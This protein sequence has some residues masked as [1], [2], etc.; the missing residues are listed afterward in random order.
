MEVDKGKAIVFEL[1]NNEY[2]LLSNIDKLVN[3]EL[4]NILLKKT[5]NNTILF[6]GYRLFEQVFS[7]KNKIVINDETLVCASFRFYRRSLNSCYGYLL[8]NYNTIS[9]KYEHRYIIY[10]GSLE[11]EDGEFKSQMITFSS[12]EDV[13]SKER[14][15]VFNIVED[16]IT[17]R[18]NDGDLGY[19]VNLH[20]PEHITK[21]QEYREQ[22]DSERWPIKIHILCW[23]HDF[24]AIHN[25]TVENH[26]VENYQQII[27][28]KNDIPYYEKIIDLI[29]D[30][31]YQRMRTFELTNIKDHSIGQSH[32]YP[33]RIGQKTFPILNTEYYNIGD[34]RFPVWTELYITNKCSNLSLNYF[35]PSFPFIANWFFI[36]ECDETFYDNKFSLLKYN[37]SKR[38]KK[39]TNKLRKLDVY[40]YIDGKTPLNKGFLKL[41]QQLHR[42]INFAET[43]LILSDVSLGVMMEYVG[44]TFRDTYKISKTTSAEATNY[45][46]TVK[47]CMEKFIF[48][49]IYAFHCMSSIVGV[50]HGDPHINNITLYQTFYN[51]D[52]NR[53][54]I[55]STEELSAEVYLIDEQ[56]FVFK[57]TGEHAMLIDF[58][59]GVLR[60]RESILEEFGEDIASDFF[61][62]NDIQ[63][64]NIVGRAFPEFNTKHGAEIDALLHDN[65][66]EF[67]RVFST[68]DTLIMCKN[69]RQFIKL[70]KAIDDDKIRGDIEEL[71]H[72]IILATEKETLVEFNKAISKSVPINEATTE[73][74]WVN[75]AI[76]ERF[77]AANILTPE[78]LSK[79]N[80]MC[81]YNYDALMKNDINDYTK[82][83]DQV[84]M[85]PRR[86]RQDEIGMWDNKHGK[87]IYDKFMEAIY[88]NKLHNEERKNKKKEEYVVEEWM[89][90]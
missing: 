85:E 87:H 47:A 16:M 38:S 58:S 89:F 4:K 30:E 63:F 77:F 56:P 80:I 82:W 10:G 34:I 39:M 14:K 67:F 20:L 75:Q 32:S 24:Y 73:E 45:I 27:Y 15:N 66:S 44:R 69:L 26:M 74:R 2:K 12:F 7:I 90:H 13:L 50:I 31:S 41:S 8:S 83:G 21:R 11:S 62:I 60:N 81:V 52:A 9:N 55:I 79:R 71:L 86:V 48:E 78:Q 54:K 70:E 88:Q 28:S 33:A 37:Y 40:N 23:L 72:Q 18:L 76:I 19:T 42:A 25:N 65:P 64:R 43:K 29:G 1:S 6:R 5:D 46:F 51:L 84:S 3:T 22:I 59:K 35:S 49:L 68:C 53:R 57:Y 36:Y 17:K 61:I